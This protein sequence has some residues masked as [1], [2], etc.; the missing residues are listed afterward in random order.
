MV[1]GRLVNKVLMLPDFPLGLAP[2]RFMHSRKK[3]GEEAAALF[4]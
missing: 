1:G 4:G 3:S 2:P